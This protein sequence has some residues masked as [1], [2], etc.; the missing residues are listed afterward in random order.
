MASQLL[1]KVIMMSQPFEDKA[2][3]FHNAESAF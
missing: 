2:I 1:A 3:E